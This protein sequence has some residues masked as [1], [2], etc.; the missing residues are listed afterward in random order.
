M[1]QKLHCPILQTTLFLFS[2]YYFF[3]RGFC[4]SKN[5]YWF[6]LTK[7]FVSEIIIENSRKFAEASVQSMSVKS[8]IVFNLMFG[9]LK[10][11]QHCKLNFFPVMNIRINLLPTIYFDKL[12]LL[13][14]SCC[15]NNKKR[16]MRVSHLLTYLIPRQIMNFMFNIGKIPILI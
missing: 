5:I 12:S 15:I 16:V 2:D 1:F 9:R 4:S 8:F 7:L 11:P 10:R 3:T 13:I 6:T 14:L